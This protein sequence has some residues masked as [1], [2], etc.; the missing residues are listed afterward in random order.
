LDAFSTAKPRVKNILLSDFDRVNAVANGDDSPANFM[1]EGEGLEWHTW[2]RSNSIS[3]NSENDLTKFHTCLC[4][5]ARN[6]IQDV[7]IAVAEASHVNSQQDFSCQGW[8]K[9]L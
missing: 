7:Q 4:R 8:R 9:R 2:R 5:A 1:T 6:A 3:P